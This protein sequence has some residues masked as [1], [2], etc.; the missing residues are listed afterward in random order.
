MNRRTLLA[1]CA[2]NPLAPAFFAQAAA[3]GRIIGGDG[4]RA[5]YFPNFVL[6]T[7]DNKRVQFYDD[8][9]EGK[10]VVINMM[11]AKCDGICPGM[12]ANLVKV[13]QALGGRVGRDIF[14]YSLTLQPE[15]D[16]PAVLKQYAAMNGVKPGWLFLTGKRT[17]MEVL[18]RKLGFFDPDPLVDADKSQH[19]G[20]VRYGNE[21]RDR[22]AACPALSEP[23][24]IAKAILSMDGPHE[25]QARK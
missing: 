7:H 16:T 19:I 13:Q 9:I 1:H 8:L 25:K 15:L 21:A 3:T 17:E 2:Q 14:M 20:L 22:W 23:E 12:T 18:R 5:S 24:Q 6:N 11:Y 4:P 10:I